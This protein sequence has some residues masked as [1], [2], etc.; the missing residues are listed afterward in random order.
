MIQTTTNMPIQCD[1]PVQTRKAELPYSVVPRRS[2]FAQFLN[3]SLP[4]MQIDMQPVVDLNAEKVV[5]IDMHE[6]APKIPEASVNYHRN[7][8]TSNTYLQ[9]A[10]RTEALKSLDIVQV[11]KAAP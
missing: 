5:Y 9:T 6:N 2:L 8:L 3:L 7:K 1:T 4:W 10:W 11:C